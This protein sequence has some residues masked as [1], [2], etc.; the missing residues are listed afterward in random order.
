[1]TRVGRSQAADGPQLQQ[2]CVGVR[3]TDVLH[4]DADAPQ[5]AP[6]DEVPVLDMD[7][8]CAGIVDCEPEVLTPCS[9]A[10]A[11]VQ[12]VARARGVMLDMGRVGEALCQAGWRE[13]EGE[14]WVE[15]RVLGVVVAGV[16][17]VVGEEEL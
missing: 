13:G 15:E 14:C 3:P 12:D 17:K 9:R 10:Y 6:Q 1:M 4:A 8:C 5:V 7:R 2:C 11:L 16:L